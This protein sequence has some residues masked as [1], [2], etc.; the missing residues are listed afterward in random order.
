MIWYNSFTFKSVSLSYYYIIISILSLS[1][2]YCF[3][4]AAK[5]YLCHNR[6]IQTKT[7]S[8]KYN[9]N[10]E[11]VHYTNYTQSGEFFDSLILIYKSTY[12]SHYVV[13]VV[14]LL[15]MLLFYLMLW[16]VWNCAYMYVRKEF[17]DI[18]PCTRFR[19]VLQSRQS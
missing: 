5:H 8:S 18:Y 2:C 14:V 11:L 4:S 15:L 17:N 9:H 16:P 10:L 12:I 13:F 7:K 6:Q 1:L 3:F 19:V